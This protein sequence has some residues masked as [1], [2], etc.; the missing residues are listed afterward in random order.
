MDRIPI[1]GF[2]ETSFL[3]WPGRIVS[4]VFLPFCNFRCPYCQ[5]STLILQPHLLKTIPESYILKQL[6]AFEGWIDGVCITGGEPTL[7]RSLPD[8]ITIFKR[9]G[10]L[11]KLDT[12]GSSPSMLKSLLDKDLIDCVAMDV[13]APLEDDLYAR[14][15]GVTFDVN[16]LKESIE[17]IRN[18]SI[19]TIFR[20]TVVPRLLTEEDI[21]RVARDLAP[22]KKF[23][24]QQFSPE[25]SLDPHLRKI[26]PWP[27]KEL[28]RVQ[29]RVDEIIAGNNG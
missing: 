5:N 7:H 20:L 17:V 16:T 28:D 26:T 9:R 3:D 21:Y 27:Q 2:L 11:V 13:K 25:N 22:V 10:F 4:V 12:N 15:I 23:I 24:L 29:H 19:E 1:K 14:L 18:S 8:F 6:E